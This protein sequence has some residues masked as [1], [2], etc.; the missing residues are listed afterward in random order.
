[1]LS[2]VNL[3]NKFGNKVNHTSS[4][5]NLASA[6]PLD[7]LRKFIVSINTR[8]ASVVSY[9]KR[10]EIIYTECNLQIIKCT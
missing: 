10:L 3:E 7:H 2:K 5:R 1:M 9:H 8:F 6:F 4:M